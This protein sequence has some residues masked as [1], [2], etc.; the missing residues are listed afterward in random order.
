MHLR[1]PRDSAVLC[2]ARPMCRDACRP[3][4]RSKLIG[5]AFL[6]AELPFCIFR[7]LEG[8]G[9]VGSIPDSWCQ[10]PFAAH[11]QNL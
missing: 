4:L 11:L 7:S 1:S 8:T 10:A 2:C 6:L 5:S 3:P 9:L